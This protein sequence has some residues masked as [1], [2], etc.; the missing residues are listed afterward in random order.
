VRVVI[1]GAS[2]NVGTSVLRSLIEDPNVEGVVG[3]SRRRPQLSLPK[4]QWRSADIRSA[5][6]AELFRGSDAVIHLA[7][8]IQPSRDERELVS[9]N[10][11]GSARVFDAVAE[12]GVPKLVY[13][14]SIGAYSPGPKDRAVDESHPTDGISSSF[15]SRHKARVERLLDTFEEKHPEI[16]AVRLRPALIFKGEAGTEIRRLF[17]GPLLP[18]RLVSRRLIPAIPAVRRLKFQAV[19]SYD[20]GEAYRLALRPKISGAFN[21]AAEPVLSPRRLARLMGALPVP[22]PAAALRA[23]ADLTWRA[24]LQPSPPGWVDMALK[25]PIMDTRRARDELGWQPRYDAEQ[26]LLELMEGI[27][28]GE[29]YPTPPLDADRSG[30][31]RIR[32]FLTGVGAR[33]P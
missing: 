24:H 2:G 10:V 14:S 4:V 8:L 23:A 29:D 1:T 19:H 25:V 3:I 18:R 32:E 20:V 27:R 21:I 17:V 5:D 16:E 28:Q 13:A 6:L 30:P 26:A 7:W 31:A 15:Y 9:V 12:A 33:T 22:I 11:E